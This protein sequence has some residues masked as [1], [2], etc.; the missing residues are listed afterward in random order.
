MA[1]V[2]RTPREFTAAA[3]TDS[4]V[5]EIR[6]QGLKLLRQDPAFRRLLD[7]RYR[8]EVLQTLL[9]ETGLFRFVPD[10]H[11]RQLIAATQ[12]EQFG[13]LEW[14]ARYKRQL[15]QPPGE[16]IKQEPLVAEE[17]QYAASLWIVRSG[18]GRLSHRQGA[19]HRTLAYLG[20]GQLFGLREVVHNASARGNASPALPAIPPRG[21]LPGS[22]ADSAGGTATSA[23][24]RQSSRFA[25][26]IESPRYAFG[27]PILDAPLSAS[28]DRWTRACWNS[29]SIGD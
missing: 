1:A 17:G 10:E 19:G 24:F 11:L 22:A 26:P 2:A 6:W 20:K 4:L 3:E 15:G 27:Q 13:D 14:Y 8:G 28:T 21:R 5:L 9:R 25:P 12:L 7:E 23:A 29:R 16:R 18:F